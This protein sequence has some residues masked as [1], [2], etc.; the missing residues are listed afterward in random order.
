[1]SCRVL[2]LRI[3]LAQVQSV[4]Y[5][6]FVSPNTCAGRIHAPEP[7]SSLAL[8][9]FA[10]R[11]GVETRSTRNRTCKRVWRVF[12]A[13]VV[14]RRKGEGTWTALHEDGRRDHYVRQPDL[15]RVASIS[16]SLCRFRPDVT[17]RLATMFA[18][19]QKFT[20]SAE[21]R[22]F[23]TACP[24]RKACSGIAVYG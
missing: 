8:S 4:V 1:M 10:A 23:R 13:W 24:L 16:R 21:R 14:T 19:H 3:A 11:S 20:E 9:L 2:R 22:V 17:L 7:S 6:I 18:V 12:L 5:S 15:R